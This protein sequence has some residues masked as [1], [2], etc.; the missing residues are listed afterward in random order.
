[1][2]RLSALLTTALALSLAGAA[3]YA[4][5]GPLAESWPTYNGDLSGRRFSTLTKINDKN[6]GSLTQAW[7]FRI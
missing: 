2:I 1:M 3:L 4:Q 5:K 7:S 6:V